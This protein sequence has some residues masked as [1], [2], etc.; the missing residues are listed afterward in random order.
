MNSIAVILVFIFL[1]SLVV[2][3]VVLVRL[4]VW[5]L[6]KRAYLDYSARRYKVVSLLL[7]GSLL[8]LGLLLVVYS[9]LGTYRIIWG[10]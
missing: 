1:S 3:G 5:R 4:G 8:A 7:D 6:Q 10:T 2:L 9:T